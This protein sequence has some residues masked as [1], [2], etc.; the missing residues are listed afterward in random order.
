MSNAAG[1]SATNRPIRTLFV[2]NL[3]TRL[4]KQETQRLLYTFFMQYGSVLDVCVSRH[5]KHRG[6]AYISFRDLSASAMAMRASQGFPL[7]GKPLRVQYA[8]RDSDRVSEYLGTGNALTRIKLS[9]KAG[10]SA[11]RDAE[12]A[13]TLAKKAKMVGEIQPAPISE[14]TADTLI[15]DPDNP[16][17]HIIFLEN[18]PDN[19]TAEMVEVLFNQF[20]GYKET[21]M[22][23]ARN[24]LAFIEFN[25]IQEAD[26]AK[27]ALDRFHIT[28][29]NVMKITFA[30]I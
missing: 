26:K 18:L 11:S 2:N 15:G 4:K 14:K 13:S 19:S 22:L 21:R 5:P 3:T 10:K 9:M 8:K 27:T 28:P 25:S 6:Q 20:D 16:P 12:K 17:N 30:R 7:D 1:F 24:D 29:Q 23:P